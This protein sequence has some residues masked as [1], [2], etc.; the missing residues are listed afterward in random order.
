MPYSPL[1][2]KAHRWSERHL[3]RMWTF[4]ELRKALKEQGFTKIRLLEEIRPGAR[5]AKHHADRLTIVANRM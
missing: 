3:L 5:E 2:G 1:K 4:P